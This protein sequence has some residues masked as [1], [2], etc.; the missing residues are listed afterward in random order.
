M[1][2]CV[3]R[4]GGE[5]K[6]CHV[7]WLARQVPGLVAITDVDVPGVR[8][9]PML[10]LWPGWWAK[11]NLFSPSLS[12]DLLYLDLDT[13]VVGGLEAFR[14]Q[15]RTTLLQDFYWPDKLASGFMYLTE[16]DR[17]KVWNEWGKDPAKH[18]RDFKQGGD[19]AFIASVLPNAATWQDT[20]PD[21]VVSYKVHVCR[22]GS[23][24]RA[25]GSGIIPA[26]ARVVCFHGKPRPWN[27]SDSWVPP[28]ENADGA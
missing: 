14:N 25:V 11:M 23:S 2:V 7:Q 18:M 17:C 5:Y 20:H 19:G 9:I 3:L 12:G 27:V 22:R 28:L 16:K 24:K 6:P 13:V 21:A 26:G 4:S 1:I 10:H 8:C 15:Q